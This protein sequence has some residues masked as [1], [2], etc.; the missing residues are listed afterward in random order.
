TAATILACYAVFNLVVSGCWEYEGGV[1]HPVAGIYPAHVLSATCISIRFQLH[2][3]HAAIAFS[4]D[5]SAGAGVG[6]RIATSI[7]VHS[8]IINIHFCRETVQVNVKSGPVATN[9]HVQ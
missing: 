3:I 8:H 6:R 2:A 1:S 7:L 4:L 5:G 9:S